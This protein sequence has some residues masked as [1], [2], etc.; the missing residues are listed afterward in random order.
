MAVRKPGSSGGFV[1]ICRAR[2]FIVVVMVSWDA[3]AAVGSTTRV[4]AAARYAEG[5]ESA[6]R[7]SEAVRTTR[8]FPDRRRVATRFGRRQ[9]GGVTGHDEYKKPIEE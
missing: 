8:C 6:S 3:L 5:W 1:C 4:G 9:L 2:A 7:E